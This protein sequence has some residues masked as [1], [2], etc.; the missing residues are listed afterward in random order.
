MSSTVRSV[1]IAKQR[2]AEKE[3]EVKEQLEFVAGLVRRLKTDKSILVTSFENQYD[4]LHD[5][6]AVVHGALVLKEEN[7]LHQLKNDLQCI[8]TAN[9]EL[10]ASAENMVNKSRHVRNY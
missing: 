2:L 1:G 8:S 5:Q 9:D 7:L 10:T 6:F 4:N 3:A